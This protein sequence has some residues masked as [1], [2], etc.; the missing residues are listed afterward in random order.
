[1]IPQTARQDLHSFRV[2][3]Y[4]CFTRRADALFELVDALLTAA[5]VISPAHLSLE[6]VHRRGWGSLYAAL[7]KGRIDDLTLRQLIAAQP[8][9]EGQPV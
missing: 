6:P 8:L 4:G 3:M 2:Q 9:A 1:M 7:A 5:R